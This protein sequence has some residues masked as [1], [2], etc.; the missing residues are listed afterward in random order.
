MLVLTN[1]AVAKSPVIGQVP[2]ATAG[3]V[4]AVHFDAPEGPNNAAARARVVRGLF[5]GR[6]SGTAEEVHLEG[7]LGAAGVASFAFESGAMGGICSRWVGR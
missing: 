1:A 4:K 3:S 6:C 7:S 2:N 5:G